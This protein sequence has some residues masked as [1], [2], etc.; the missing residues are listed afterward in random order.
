MAYFAKFTERAQRA[1]IAAQREAA[2]LGRDYV[3]T[4]HLLLG[5]LTD[6]G[7][8]GTVL[9]GI[10]LDAVRAQIVE[11]LGSGD[12]SQAV[13]TLV[14]TPR[15][16]KVLEQIGVKARIVRPNLQLTGGECGYA[17]HISEVFLAEALEALERNRIPPQ[18][19]LV[20]DDN[21]RYREMKP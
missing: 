2:Q 7:A 10:T 21:N 1:L 18:K 6:P 14:Y 17:V 3:G 16:K 19:V 12:N 11:M 5:V 8:A 4:E 20:S 15:T 9:K 13:K